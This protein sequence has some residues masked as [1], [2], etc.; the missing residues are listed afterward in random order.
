MRQKQQQSHKTKTVALFTDLK[1]TINQPNI[2]CQI[3]LEEPPKMH[4]PS[5]TKTHNITTTTAT[6]RYFKTMKTKQTKRRDVSKRS[7]VLAAS[8]SHKEEEYSSARYAIT[9]DEGRTDRW[10][11]NIS[12]LGDW[13]LL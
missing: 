9:A 12:W 3:P 13:L 11:N 1:L 10:T 6:W 2:S 5:I 4:I 8:K 7:N